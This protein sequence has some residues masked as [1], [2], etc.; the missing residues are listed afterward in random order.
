MEEVTLVANNLQE[1]LIEQYELDAVEA[2]I[3]CYSLEDLHL[4]EE[5]YAGKWDN[6]KEFVQNLLED[7]GA[8]PSGLPVYVHIDWEWTAQ[9]VMYDYTTHNGYY[10]RNI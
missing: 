2:F 10:F 9:E 1:Q 3:Y 4:F 7:I 6:D 5:S 8:V